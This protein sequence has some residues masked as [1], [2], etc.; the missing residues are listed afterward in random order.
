MGLKPG[1]FLQFTD[2]TPLSNLFVTAPDRLDATEPLF[3][4]S[5][6]DLTAL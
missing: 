6:S 1:R 2:D 3:A 5:T 4:D